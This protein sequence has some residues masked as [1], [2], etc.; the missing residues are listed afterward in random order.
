MSRYHETPYGHALKIA[1]RAY[2]HMV[3]RSCI[4]TGDAPEVRAWCEERF[5]EGGAQFSSTHKFLIETDR[6]WCH[7]GACFWFKN[8]DHAFEFKMRWV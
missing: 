8:P 4:K 1:A 7:L 2:P 3:P 6:A 5:G